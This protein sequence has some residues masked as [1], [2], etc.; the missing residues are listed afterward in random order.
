MCL[1]VTV[2]KFD[3]VCA[4]TRSFDNIKCSYNVLFTVIL[5]LKH[6][7]LLLSI[8]LHL[9]TLRCHHGHYSSFFHLLQSV[10]L[11]GNKCVIN[12]KL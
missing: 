10:L 8:L 4:V 2:E 12:L 6:I 7:D 3:P 9:Q 1:S 5:I 11:S